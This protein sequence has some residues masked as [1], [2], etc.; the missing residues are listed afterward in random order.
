MAPKYRNDK[1]CD[2]CELN[3]VCTYAKYAAGP[4]T[5]VNLKVKAIACKNCPCMNQF[6]TCIRKSGAGCINHQEKK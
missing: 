4:K 6:G 3:K 5:K 1:R 2:T